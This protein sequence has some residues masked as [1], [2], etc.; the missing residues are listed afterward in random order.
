[1]PLADARDGVARAGDVVLKAVSD[2]EEAE[3][4]AEV[5]SALPERGFRLGRPVR[6]TDGRWVVDGWAAYR[7]VEGENTP[8]GRWR[9]VLEA[10]L[11]LHGALAAV[12]RPAFFARR[13]S[14]WAVADRVAWGEEEIDLVEGIA[15][16]ARR[17]QARLRP[18]TAR[19]QVVH[20]DLSNNVLFAPGLAPAVIDF[21]PYWRPVVYAQAIV[22]VDALLYRGAPSSTMDLLEDPASTEYLARAWLFRAATLSQYMVAT[23]FSDPKAADLAVRARAVFTHIERRL[24]RASKSDGRH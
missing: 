8:E 18:S 15:D 14:R 24:A 5:L 4:S 13:A 10:G 20:G 17:L 2:V 1:M 21:S 6:A 22:V 11:A 3:W 23:A 16:L 9:E 19:C 12:A 7:Y